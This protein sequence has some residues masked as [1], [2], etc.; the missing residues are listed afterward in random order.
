[1]RHGRHAHNNWSNLRLPLGMR[2]QKSIQLQSLTDPPPGAVPPG[3][4][5]GAL[6]P[7]PHYSLTLR[8]R[9]GSHGPCENVFPGPS[10]G[11]R[12]AWLHLYMV[13]TVTV[14]CCCISR[15]SDKA[16][17]FSQDRH[18]WC[19]HWSSLRSH[20]SDCHSICNHH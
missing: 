5:L 10:C 9:H 16:E 3:P 14:L 7:D 19:S 11:S 17:H 2:K 13:S 20:G 4:Q 15:G 6:P 8:A 12:R 1:M 18:E